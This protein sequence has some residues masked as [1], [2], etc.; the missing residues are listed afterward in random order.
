MSFGYSLGD[1]VLALRLADDLK[2]RFSQAPKEFKIVLDEVKRVWAVLHDI[3]DI[4]IDGLTPQQSQQMHEVLQGCQEVLGDLKVQLDKSHIL[5]HTTPD[6][7]DKARRAWRRIAWDQTE[8]DRLRDRVTSTV[9]LFNLLMSKINQTLSLELR[10]ES[11]AVRRGY[12]EGFRQRLLSQI[13]SINGSESQSAILSSRQAGTGD[14]FAKSA[15]FCGWVDNVKQMLYCPGIPGA[16]KTV[17]CSIGIDHL[18]QRFAGDA[19]IGI[20][21]IFFDFRQDWGFAGILAA[22]LRQL[23]QGQ[24]QIPPSTRSLFAQGG[25]LRDVEHE[26]TVLTSTFTKTFFVLDALDECSASGG[27]RRQL[28]EFLF[29]LQATANVNIFATSR[30][31]EEVGMSFAKRGGAVWE[32]QASDHDIH[33]YIDQRMVYFPSFVLNKPNIQAYIRDEISQASRGMFLLAKLYMNLL[34]DEVNEKRIRKIVQQFKN[35]TEAYDGA[36]DQ[37]MKRIERQGQYAQELAKTTLGWI[38]ALA[39]GSLKFV[40]YTTQ[41]YFQRNWSHCACLTYVSLGLFDG[42]PCTTEIQLRERLDN[43]PFYKYSA[44]NWGYHYQRHAGDQSMAMDFLHTEAKVHASSQVIFGWVP[45][46]GI[47]VRDYGT[48]LGFIRWIGVKEPLH[49]AHL[50][51]FF[52]LLGPIDVLLSRNMLDINLEDQQGR[53][54]LTWATA[55]GHETLVHM[56]LQRGA[57]PNSTN[58][59]GFSPLFYATVSGKSSIIRSLIEA[60]AEVNVVDKNGRTPLFHAAEGDSSQLMPLAFE[61]NC[62]AAI[63]LLLDYGACATQVDSLGQTPL[64]AAAKNGRDSCV[65][66][67]ISREAHSYYA[68]TSHPVVFDPLAYAAMN[69]HATTAKLLLDCRAHP[70][71]TRGREQASSSVTL[72]NLLNAG[73]NGYDDA[74]RDLLVAGADLT[75]RDTCQRSPLHWAAFTGND[76]L[77][78]CLLANGVDVNAADIFGRTP[79]FYALFGNRQ[80]IAL[81][82]LDRPD[83]DYNY[84]DKSGDTVLAQAFKRRHQQSRWKI[85]NL[86]QMKSDATGGLLSDLGFLREQQALLRAKCDACLN[87]VVLPFSCGG[88]PFIAQYSSAGVPAVRYCGDCVSDDKPKQCPL[89]G[90]SLTPSGH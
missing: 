39:T 24:E 82:L 13:S 32:I 31:D 8:I 29:G 43:Y 34:Q 14:W 57:N 40:H 22:L 41:E 68:N 26:L 67:L 49:G 74:F 72:A 9:S 12:D 75:I 54:L 62:E 42:G 30:P 73:S 10:D 20:S 66:L 36:Y 77:V 76:N 25:S 79:I 52:G 69:G 4:P 17:L 83:I 5:A 64:F 71:S 58:K 27:V 7:K 81:I 51:A 2:K 38:H 88:C 90:R 87:K 6:W 18:E 15:E 46:G 60:G 84:A 85:Y 61:G 47:P 3:D 33:A 65:K 28:L 63:K 48:M 70:M 78:R 21:Y 86:L 37:T 59:F 50:A 45:S 80:S 23:V 55:Y 53:T 19:N 44:E 56:L 16:G 35:G 11:Q 1:I 89:C